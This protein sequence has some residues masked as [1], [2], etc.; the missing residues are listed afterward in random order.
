[1]PFQKL[2]RKTVPAHRLKSGD[3]AR[4]NINTKTVTAENVD[5]AAK[6][7]TVSMISVR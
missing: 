6:H 4:T 3:C 2:H 1:M 5:G 7:H